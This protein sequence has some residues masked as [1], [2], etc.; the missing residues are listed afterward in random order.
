MPNFGLVF[1]R[2]I[3]LYNEESRDGVGRHYRVAEFNDKVYL[4]NEQGIEE[5]RTFRCERVWG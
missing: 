1:I 2:L 5:E 3:I 4:R